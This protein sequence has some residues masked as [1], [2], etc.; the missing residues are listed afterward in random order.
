MPFDVCMQCMARRRRKALS[1][2]GSWKCTNTDALLTVPASLSPFL[3]DSALAGRKPVAGKLDKVESFLMG[4]R[5]GDTSTH[6]HS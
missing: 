4:G 6:T 1:K 2:S 3:R 5:E